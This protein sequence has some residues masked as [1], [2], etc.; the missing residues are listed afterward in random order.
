MI[1]N[2]FIVGPRRLRH[3]NSN[4][5]LAH[6]DQYVKST[7]T[8][9]LLWKPAKICVGVRGGEAGSLAMDF[10]GADPSPMFGDESL[11]GRQ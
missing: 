11:S 2:R 6:I 10:A 3:S 4:V 9:V 5:S 8:Y 7:V 1:V